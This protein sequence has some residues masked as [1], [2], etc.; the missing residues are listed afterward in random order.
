VAAIGR[1]IT[2]LEQQ[3]GTQ[4]ASIQAARRRQ[5]DAGLTIVMQLLTWLR[6]DPASLH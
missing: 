3:Y 5:Q 1:D 6:L 4:H 2:V